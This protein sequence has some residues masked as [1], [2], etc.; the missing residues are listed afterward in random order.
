MKWLKSTLDITT[1]N[2]GFHNITDK[3]NAQIKSWD[4]EEGIIFLFLQ[5]TSAS[6]VINEDY[7]ADARRDMEN[8]FDQ[9]VPE[10]ASWYEHTIEG[11]DDS[12][13]HLRTMIT[14]TH[15]SIPVDGGKM[16]LGTWQGIF[17][18]EHRRRGHRRQIQLRMLSVDGD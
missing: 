7:A 18:A 17:L 16:T 9:L 4:A 2:R 15:L 11:K 3:I 12:P 13:A 6:L 10:G 1:H 5:H 14:H 8:F